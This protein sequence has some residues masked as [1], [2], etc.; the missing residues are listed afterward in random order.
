MNNL[1]IRPRLPNSLADDSQATGLAFLDEQIH[2]P[3]DVAHVKL[4]IAALGS[5]GGVSRLLSALGHVLIDAGDL[6]PKSIVDLG[7]ELRVTCVG[8]R[9][10]VRVSVGVTDAWQRL[11]T[12]P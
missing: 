4:V 1:Y 7:S 3:L 8:V 6:L 2:T 5:S 12:A 10:G 11:L 9:V